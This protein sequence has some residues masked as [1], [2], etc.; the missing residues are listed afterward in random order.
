MSAG[1]GR[2]WGEM[3]DGRDG[4][5]EKLFV[6]Q[7]AG[8]Y[9]SCRNYEFALC[10]LQGGVGLKLQ[11]RTSRIVSFRICTSRPPHR[12]S[13][14]GRRTPRRTNN[15]ISKVLRRPPSPTGTGDNA[16][17]IA[18]ESLLQQR[19]ERSIAHSFCTR[20][21]TEPRVWLAET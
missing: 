16:S 3:E 11:S 9:I 8:K 12:G 21:T 19:M 4:R 15:H 2:W 1:G 17:A 7:T 6:S 5:R 10:R 13:P 14:Q 18:C 20:I